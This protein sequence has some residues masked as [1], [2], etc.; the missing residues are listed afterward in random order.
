M[1][2]VLEVT[3]AQCKLTWVGLAAW[4]ATCTE[5]RKEGWTSRATER[6]SSRA[7]CCNLLA[8]S[9]SPAVVAAPLGQADGCQAAE[10]SAGRRV[11]AGPEAGLGVLHGRRL[12]APWLVAA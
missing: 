9:A 4:H 11:P 6:A 5:K 12:K 3:L 2:S 10:A 8:S 1:H 7:L